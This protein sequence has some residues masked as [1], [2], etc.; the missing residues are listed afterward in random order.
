MFNIKE[1]LKRLPDNPGVY[2]MFND[3]D[4]IIYVGKAK[5]LK[6]R[7]RQYFTSSDIGKT[8][9]VIEMVKH[10]KRF[11]YIIV[12]N[13]VE[14]LILESN[15][16]K[17]KQPKYNI[18]LKNGE[19]YPFIK[20]SNE[21]FPRI[22]KERVIKKD[23]SKYYGPFPNAYAVTEII[24]IFLNMFKIRRCTLNFDK[25]Q[26][27]KRP[28]L[29]YFIKKC[30]APCIKNISEEDYMK[31]IDEVE[32][33]LKGKENKIIEE[34]REKMFKASKDLN[35]ELAA[36]YRDN[37]ENIEAIIEKQKV[38][39]SKGTNMDIIAL[40]RHGTDV[41]VQAFLMRNGKIIDREHFLIED[42]FK[43]NDSEIMSSFL[44]QFYLDMAF[45]PK[46]ILVD[47][48]PDDL[49]SIE[50]FL[51]NEKKGTVKVTKPQ[52]GEK[53]KQLELV[54]AN[55]KEM[56][57][58]YITSKHKRERSKS[59]AF[60]ELKKVTGLEDFDRVECYDIS[61]ISG[62][63]SVGSMIV[64][65]NGEKAPKEYRKFKIKTVVG[66]DD[67]GSHREVLTRRFSRM[68]IEN[69]EGNF[70]TGFGI[71]PS[72]ILMDGGK[73]QVNVALEVLKEFNIDIPV[74]GL[75]KDDYHKTKGIIYKNSEYLLKVKSPLYRLLF[76]IQEEA[77]RFA[78]NYHRKLRER[79]LKKSELDEIEGIGV[80]R[81]KAL[82]KYFKSIKKIKEASIEELAK[83]D[84]MNLSA[85]ESIY[86]FF[87]KE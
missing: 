30:S 1:E 73:G 84:K 4:E 87:H 29:Y 42:S 78:I 46:E 81:K 19:K 52:R 80:V 27:L 10:I 71:K 12:D 82:I 45:I 43:E 6:K 16:I 11:E 68:L 47:T 85:A 34:T 44:K 58:K 26:Y 57:E 48:L 32:M 64:F 50:E 70:S 33:L 14:S 23:G 66:A 61:N 41:C 77:H 67:Y 54:K 25:G 59:S 5:N 74:M 3:D 36:R 62:V 22:T 75:V 31:N 7:V 56:L 17:D 55:A 69:K 53:V 20:I 65:I 15:F 18:L 63:Q 39:N 51:T 86:K 60:D 83:I 24:E 13:E 8:D 2:L 35:F 79:D 40:E 49:E 38:R 72:I 76:Q 28:C 37:I 21:K 9:K